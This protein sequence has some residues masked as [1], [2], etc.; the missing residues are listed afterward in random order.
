[1]AQI[2]EVLFDGD[3]E[4]TCWCHLIV[5]K[6][7]MVK[8]DSLSIEKVL[9]EQY[10]QK[11]DN[12]KYG[13]KITNA[14][15][16]FV[17]FSQTFEYYTCR[18]YSNALPLF[19]IKNKGTIIDLIRK[20][21]D[22]TIKCINN[23]IENDESYLSCNGYYNYEYQFSNEISKKYLLL[24]FKDKTTGKLKE[25]RLHVIQIIDSH[26]GYLDNFRLFLLNEGLSIND[27]P[28]LNNILEVIGSYIKKYR[29]IF[30]I[31][32]IN[33]KKYYYYVGKNNLEKHEKIINTFENQLKKVTEKP[34]DVNNVITGR[35]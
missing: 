35:Q 22:N 7:A 34:F 16:S 24:H 9:Q 5:L 20:I 2:L 6:F 14:G 29:D 23:I 12:N 27:M 11:E 33:D 31:I 3:R 18:Y 17:H 4:R 19:C 21:R 10:D 26:I 28:F 15:K 8:A 25:E 13:V 1:M 32:E 30:E